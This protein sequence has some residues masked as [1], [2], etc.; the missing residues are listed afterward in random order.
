MTRN[1]MRI[2]DLENEYVDINT[3]DNYSLKENCSQCRFEAQV[4]YNLYRSAQKAVL[5][6][7]LLKAI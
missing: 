5:W 7:I 3:L 1:E 2:K 6:A 4:L